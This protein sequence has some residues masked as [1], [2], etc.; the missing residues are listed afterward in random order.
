MLKNKFIKVEVQ[1]GFLSGV[2]GCVEHAFAL[3]EALREAKSHMRQI[4]I[5]WLDLANAY[6]SVR[7]NLIQF[8]MNWYHV[9]KLIHDLIF[10]Y[11][12]KLMA[13]IETVNWSTGFSCLIWLVPR[14]CAL[15]TL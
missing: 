10:D 11:Y 7:H 13:K 5:S 8:A 15:Y 9:P 4:V 12:E 1:K 14:L 3:F 6:G 2:A